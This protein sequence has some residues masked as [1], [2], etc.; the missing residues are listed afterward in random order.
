MRLKDQVAIVTGSSRGIG[1]AI[2]I[3][4]AREGAKVVVTARTEDPEQ[5]K[6]PGTIHE[7]ADAIK[8]GGGECLTVRC[9][10]V[11]Q[12]DLESLVNQVIDH[13][14]G[15]DVLVNNAAVILYMD[16]VDTSVKRWDLLL[17][18]NLRAP[19][20]LTQ[21]ALPHMIRQ[22]SGSIINLDSTGATDLEGGANLYGASKAAIRR[23]SQGL[24]HEVKK[25]NIAVNA[26]DPG[27]VKTEGAVLTNPPDKD[28]A[29]YKESADVVPS[30]LY[31]ADPANR[32]FTGH[33]VATDDFGVAWP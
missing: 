31:L 13:Y 12:D 18:I 28:W 19:V 23:F 7:T 3:G 11:Q 22:N 10:L 16:L 14:G 24:A 26:L 25:H 9:N 8:A 17:N 1:K 33:A 32:G 2:A 20:V 6:L 27:A 5:S 15:I 4:Y 30:A 21:L 29:G